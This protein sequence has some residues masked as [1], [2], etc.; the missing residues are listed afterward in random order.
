MRLKW[1]AYAV[2]LRAAAQVPLLIAFIACAI[3]ACT[4]VAL[5]ELEPSRPI[6]SPLAPGVYSGTV[7]CSATADLSGET[8]TADPGS[9]TVVV[10]IDS[11]GLPL[12]DGV[13]VEVGAMQTVEIFGGA[14]QGTITGIQVVG[15]TLVVVRSLEGA[16]AGAI[17][18]Q[19]QSTDE[20]T[21]DGDTLV[22]SISTTVSAAAELTIRESCTGRLARQ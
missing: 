2:Q 5:P 13:A 11:A 20:Y 6:T 1:L 19:G 7:E 22:V 12:Q 3:G 14:L 9:A 17:E 10:Q 4:G 16:F 18:L 8:T 15:S 21:N